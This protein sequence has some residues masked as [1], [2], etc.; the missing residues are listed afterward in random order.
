MIRFLLLLLCVKVSF[1]G[2]SGARETYTREV[3]LDNYLAVPLRSDT[4]TMIMR[5]SSQKEVPKEKSESIRAFY[6]QLKNSCEGNSK[7]FCELKNINEDSGNQVSGL[8]S[9][10]GDKTPCILPVEF[11]IRI[12]R[13]LKE[14]EKDY[15]SISDE[16]NSILSNMKPT[17]DIKISV[18]P[19]RTYFSDKAKIHNLLQE[20][21][22]QHILEL[23]MSL[24][25]D[26][27]IIV[28]GY[29]HTFSSSEID[30]FNRQYFYNLKFDLE[31]K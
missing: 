24:G 27:K 23:R 18:S 17:G 28:S 4:V 9:R 15:F 7:Y 3:E 6:K 14:S 20:R 13:A 19:I 8:F 29:S 25:P 26:T 5:V 10:S 16:F 31:I 30:F 12:S 2:F 1:G 21:L 22:A 11:T